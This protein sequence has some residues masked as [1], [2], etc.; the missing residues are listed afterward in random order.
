MT[1]TAVLVPRSE[2]ARE[3]GDAVA[4]RTAFVMIPPPGQAYDVAETLP[5]VE[6]LG[7]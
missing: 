3:I 6:V 4:D 1:S 2:A 7:G 5:R